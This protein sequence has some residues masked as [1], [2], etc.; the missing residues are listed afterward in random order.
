L[1]E[2]LAQ[3]QIVDD[4]VSEAMKVL[5]FTIEGLATKASDHRSNP[6]KHIK[7]PREEPHQ[8]ATRGTTSKTSE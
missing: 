4:V 2:F 3:D 7:R 8:E 5:Q 1:D 6:R